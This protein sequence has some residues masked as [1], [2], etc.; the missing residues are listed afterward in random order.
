MCCRGSIA[1]T[2][3]HD[4]YKYNST[5]NQQSLEG[6]V[7]WSNSNVCVSQVF[8][9][10]LQIS[11][12][13][14]LIFT[15]RFHTCVCMCVCVSKNKPLFEIRLLTMRI[16][17]KHYNKTLKTIKPKVDNVSLFSTPKPNNSE[18]SAWCTYTHNRKQSA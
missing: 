9:I 3:T 18:E 6:G 7:I 2:N 1:S 12:Q 17:P 11:L 4:L 8:T 10:F 15:R 13:Y 14:K 5:D 16:N